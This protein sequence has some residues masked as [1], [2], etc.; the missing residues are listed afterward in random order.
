MFLPEGF[1]IAAARECA[2]LVLQAYDQFENPAVWKIP[3]AYQNLGNLF[4][5]NEAFGFVA[6]NLATNDVFVTFRGTQTTMDW[7]AN[8]TLPPVHYLWGAAER[9]FSTLYA[10]CAGSIATA[11]KRSDVPPPR[12]VYVSGHSL[13]GA[14]AVLAAADIVNSLLAEKPKMYTF[15]GP[16]AV[17]PGFADKFNQRIANAWRVVNTEDIVTTVPLATV[18]VGDNSLKSGALAAILHSSEEVNYEHV[19]IP[20]SFTKH[21]GSII[22]N[23]NMETVY[24]AAL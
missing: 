5:A 7:L 4:A 11:L 17:D 14:L 23:H 18:V 9:G 24:R 16:R 3:P 6:R 10:A 13:G 20:V 12:T 19:G 15:A 22:A 1:D 8:L 21:C 2:D